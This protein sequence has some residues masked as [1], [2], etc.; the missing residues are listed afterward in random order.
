MTLLDR[1]ASE[2]FRESHV[3]VIETERLVLRAPR[4]EDA[5]M[6]ATL[7]NDRRIAENTL[8]IPHPYGLADAQAFIAS[9]NAG[10]GEIVLVIASRDG[11][12]LGCRGIAQ[13]DEATP[14]IGYWLGV[15]FWG[16]GYATEAARADRPCL[17]RPR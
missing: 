4:F 1:S 14:E 13:L 10:D 15:P 11:G 9:A 16:K 3:P 6:I 17:R 12:V 8:R 7:V 2:T 5:N